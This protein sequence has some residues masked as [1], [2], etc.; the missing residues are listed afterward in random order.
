MDKRSSKPAAKR[1]TAAS[2]SQLV[3]DHSA[4]LRDR[5]QALGLGCI[6][7]E[8]LGWDI[9]HRF[10]CSQGHTLQL[11]PGNLLNRGCGSCRTCQDEARF[12]QLQADAAAANAVCLD[13][14]WHGYKAIYRFRCGQGHEW[15]RSAK[16]RP[17]CPVCIKAAADEGRRLKDGLQLLVQAAR[18]RG[19]VCLSETYLGQAQ[20]HRFRC[21]EGHEWQSTEVLRGAWCGICAIAAKRTQYRLANGL[22]RLQ[23]AAIDKGGLCLSQTYEGSKMRYRFRC[24][25]GHAWETLGALILRGAW[26]LAC[27]CNQKRGRRPPN[28]LSKRPSAFAFEVICFGTKA[29]MLA[30]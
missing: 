19:G 24:G 5:I 7:P 3:L 9:K 25:K 16:H 21:A 29:T 26:C 20:H 14:A 12:T 11:S 28:P 6:E 17:G 10:V 18:E 30:S 2:A 23:Q 8:W 15:S 27:A 1:A 22:A 13:T 4:K